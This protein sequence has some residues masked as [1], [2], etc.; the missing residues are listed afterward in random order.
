MRSLVSA[1]LLLGILLVGC[2]D[3]SS[4]EGPGFEPTSAD[5]VS[6]PPVP[7]PPGS[8]VPPIVECPAP[9]T[10]ALE[11]SPLRVPIP[12]EL[13]TSGATVLVTRLHQSHPP[14]ESVTQ[15]PPGT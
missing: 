11:P 14:R 13:R 10:P 9:P 6:G 5:R 2:G 4:E 8:P 12:A 1:P 7:P 3:A 15:V